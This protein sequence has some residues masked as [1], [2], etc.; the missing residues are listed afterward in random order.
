MWVDR[1]ETLNVSQ[2]FDRM[3]TEELQHYAKI[4]QL[5]NGSGLAYHSLGA[6]THPDRV[7]G[8]SLGRRAPC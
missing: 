8:P 6:P 2:T 5:P 1:T 7:G 3:S 4:D